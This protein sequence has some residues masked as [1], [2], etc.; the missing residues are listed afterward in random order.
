MP[1]IVWFLEFYSWI[2]QATKDAMPG[3][4]GP[5]AGVNLF[6]E[7]PIV[8]NSVVA[9]LAAG[10][11]KYKSGET[12]LDLDFD[13]SSLYSFLPLISQHFIYHNGPSS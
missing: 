3:Y 8:P 6:I 10:C 1:M 12:T 13:N 2:H 7:A 5:D 9:G 11:R 4:T